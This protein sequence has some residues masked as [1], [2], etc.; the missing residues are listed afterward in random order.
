MDNIIGLAGYM[1]LTGAFIIVIFTIILAILPHFKRFFGLRGLP[2][3]L[4]HLQTA[5]LGI[6]VVALAILLQTSA[7][8]YEQV[9][10]AVETLMRP[11]ERIGGLWSGQAASLLFWS[12]IMSIAVSLAVTISKR[13]GDQK[14]T[15]TIILILEFTLLFFLAP[16]IFVSNPF[17]R[18]FS[19]PN[20]EI[21]TAMFAPEG[22]Q[23]LLPMD[24]Q[25]MN[26][27]LRHIA[28]L[29]HPPTLYLGL[30]GFFL[31]YAFALTALLHQDTTHGWIKKL[32]PVTLISFV[33]LTLGM[34]L[35]SW[36]AYTILGWGG[37]WGWDA[38]EISGLL[39]WLLSFGSLHAM[40]L[41]MRKKDVA[42]WVYA[43]S[44][45]IVIL[46][47]FGILITRSGI[48]E[49]V[50]A[51]ASGPMGPI[52]TSLVVIH[53]SLVLFAVIRSRKSIFVRSKNKDGSLSMRINRWFFWVIVGL[54][55]I[56]L[57]GQTLPLTSQLF[58]SE[59]LSFKPADYERYSAPL[60]VLLV[61]LTG[62][63]PLAD[64]YGEQRHAFWV[65]LA[66]ISIL[67][68]AFPVAALFFTPFS[69]AIA[70]GFWATGFLLLSW[71]Y[72]GIR[73]IDLPI[74]RG[75]PAKSW[76]NR[77]GMVIIHFGFAIM[78]VGIIAVE[79]M[80]YDFNL[81]LS[82]DTPAVFNQYTVTYNTQSSMFVEE[83]NPTYTANITIT[84]PKDKRIQ[85]DPAITHYIKTGMFYPIPAIRPGFLQD[86]QVVLNKFP[87][88]PIANIDIHI[89]FFPLIS[90]IWAGGVL[91]A[92]GGV[93][94]LFLRRM[95]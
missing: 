54:V 35:G 76:S 16:D 5:L 52:L 75:K 11:A 88:S 9:F 57:F 15:T 82:P 95:K 30:V 6:S 78:A 47:L 4:V 37:Y 68:V 13:L 12:F 26:P 32:F 24:G 18:I 87:P 44:F 85:S 17:V 65:I 49:S 27:S 59:K 2:E 90:W 3:V 56:Y 80:A 20:G 39:P 89:A 42:H 14:Q 93:L 29:L 34:L 72:A 1:G 86:V 43:F 83:G 70:I 77:L 53:L 66:G 40:R 41:T 60:L 51:Y 7:F 25:G 74:L 62:L 48:L 61:F 22:A 19:M 21:L 58:T 81:T 79:T 38:V 23:A 28:M 33:F 8:Q 10:T 69:V 36:W 67:A 91:M 84:A 92:L 73:D 45:A 46:T 50:H 63:C 55:L 31:P 94:P 71:I 64:H